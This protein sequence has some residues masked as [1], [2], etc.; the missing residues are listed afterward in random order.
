MGDATKAIGALAAKVQ[1]SV[2]E[3]Q[4]E[5]AERYGVAMTAAAAA[6]I[7]KAASEELG[8]GVVV[9]YLDVN[10]CCVTSTN[11]EGET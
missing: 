11:H 10:G 8:R 2:F 3:N 9:V 6:A 4:A 7:E 5:A 1:S